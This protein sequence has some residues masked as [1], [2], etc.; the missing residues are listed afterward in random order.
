[1][2]RFKEGFKFLFAGAI[3]TAATMVLYWILLRYW[4]YRI[5]YTTSYAI[6]IAISYL[7]NAYFVFKASPAIKSAVL[8]PLV[9]LVQYIIGLIVLWGW[10]G[11]LGFG[12]F[13]GVI[14]AVLL[15]LPV[16][17]LLSRRILR[18]A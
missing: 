13:S 9:Y 17:F 3:N 1:M 16:T 10:V 8:Y 7:L 5:A 11:G 12:P 18:L 4:D 15:S 6:G 2:H 14:A